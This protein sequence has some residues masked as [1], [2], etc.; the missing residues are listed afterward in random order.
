MKKPTMSLTQ[1]NAVAYI[2]AHGGRI[3]YFRGG[4]WTTPD[5][6]L[7]GGSPIGQVDAERRADG[8]YTYERHGA[9]DWYIGTR[10]VQA[11][12]RLGVLVRAGVY[13]EAWRDPRLLV[14]SRLLSTT[15]T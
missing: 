14:V 11:M 15:L 4:F 12:E 7:P 1:R 2:A 3:D 13:A 5:T 10:T 6:R 9:P 8:G